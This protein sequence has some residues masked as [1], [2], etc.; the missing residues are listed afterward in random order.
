MPRARRH[1]R[2]VRRPPPR[3]GCAGRSRMWRGPPLADFRYEP[4]AQ[5]EIARLEEARLDCLAERIE[6][7]LALGHHAKLVGELEALT[8]EHPLRERPRGQ[9]MLALYRSGRQAD[10]LEVYQATREPLV[11]ELGIEPGGELRELHQAI[12]RQDAELELPRAPI[13]AEPA[14]SAERSSPSAALLPGGPQDGHRARDRPRRASGGRASTRSCAGGSATGRS[15]SSRRCS[16]ATARRS[17]GCGTVASWPSSACR[18]PT[19]TTRCA[20][21][22]RRS[23]CATPSPAARETVRTGIDS[24]E[25]L[26]GDTGSGEPLVTGDAV[27]RPRLLQQASGPGEILIGAATHGS[28]ARRSRVSRSTRRRPP[29]GLATAR[30][31]CRALRPSCGASTLRWSAATASSP[32]SARPSSARCASGAPSSS[33]S[34]ARPGSAR[35]VLRRSSPARSRARRRSSPAA[36]SRTARASPTGL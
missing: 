22:G 9:L 29:A 26:T 32:S 17:S 13:A 23:S 18:P 36:A 3:P 34:S 8:A 11:E 27:E 35:P 4:F 21:S 14:D 25:V 1:S 30:A 12:L 10:A 5:A 15:R 7:D 24:G 6:A 16:S 33:P 28:S 31:A 2:P 20:P 19:R